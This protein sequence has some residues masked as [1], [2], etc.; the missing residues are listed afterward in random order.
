MRAVGRTEGRE[1]RRESREVP[2]A[3]IMYSGTSLIRTTKK[4]S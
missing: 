4:V 1:V 2:P 3:S